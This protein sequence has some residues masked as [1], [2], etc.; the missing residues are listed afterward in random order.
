[1]DVNMQAVIAAARL[2]GHAKELASVGAVHHWLIPNSEGAQVQRID[3][4]AGLSAPLRKR[5]TVQVFDATSFNAVLD[6]NHADG[7]AIYVSRD[8]RTPAIV[9][10]INGNGINGP[11]WGDFRAEILFR[12]TPQWQRWTGAWCGAM[13]R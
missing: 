6:A 10:V 1:M 7:I 4:E 3:M 11:G 12:F 13:R 5:G 8:A 2:T 9:A